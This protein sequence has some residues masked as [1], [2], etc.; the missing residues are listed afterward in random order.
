MWRISFLTL[1][2]LIFLIWGM[3]SWQWG[4]YVEQNNS[5]NKELNEKAYQH[6]SIETIPNQLQI[7]QSIYGFTPGKTYTFLVPDLIL[8]WNCVKDDGTACNSEKDDPFSIIAEDSAISLKY[9]IKLP[10]DHSPFL[11]HDW[12]AA[13]QDVQ[14]TETRMEL[15]D[16]SKREGTWVAGIPL[17]A[18][19]KLNYIDYYVFVGGESNASI[20]WQPEPLFEKVFQNIHIY[21]LHEN[22]SVP[23]HS[24]E[25]LRLLPKIPISS[26]VLSDQLPEE[27]GQGLLVL[28][29]EI[30]MR[31]ME[32]KMIY[33]YFLNNFFDLSTEEMWIVDVLTSM[34][35]GGNSNTKKG[36]ELIQELKENLQPEEWTQY[37][38]T[39]I[40][41]ESLSAQ[42]LDE[43]LSLLKGK[44]TNYFSLNRNQ[45]KQLVPLYYI[46]SRDLLINDNVL[47]DQHAILVEDEMFFPFIETMRALSF[48]INTLGTHEIILTNKDYNTYR[49]YADQNIFIY[50]E[51]DYG[52][53]ENPLTIIDGKVYIKDEWLDSLFQV[54]VFEEKKQIKLS[55]LEK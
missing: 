12:T 4:T 15:I 44:D 50:N 33:Q 18:H 9:S 35:V 5:S 32:R 52:L 31:D 49:F 39:I 40:H 43:L 10:N 2:I 22:I 13:V 8:D 46:D 55:L 34:A 17:K 1:I 48:K 21:S 7:T 29:P 6:I 27:A 53:L 37:I 28:N 20:F 16:L 25:S 38:S 41:A 54:D 11:F 47:K 24:F 42:K 36:N 51:E 3:L 14:I 45:N 23:I 19:K 30:S 26:I